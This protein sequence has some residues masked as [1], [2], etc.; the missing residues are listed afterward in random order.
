MKGFNY[1]WSWFLRY[2]VI[3]LIIHVA[4]TIITV[5]QLQSIPFYIMLLIFLL[6]DAVLIVQNFFVQV[7][8][9]RAKIGV[10][11]SL[12]FFVAQYALS[13]IAVNSDNPTAGVNFTI[14]IVPHAA[15]VLAFRTMLFA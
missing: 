9:S 2:I 10:V 15:F 13:F 11:I 8:L 5:K 3:Y 1:Y 7:F 12:L 4:C 14:S 6:F